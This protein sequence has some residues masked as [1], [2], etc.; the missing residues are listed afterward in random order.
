[1][2]RDSGSLSTQ[3]IVKRTLPQQSKKLVT[4]VERGGQEKGSSMISG[5]LFSAIILDISSNTF[6][7][8]DFSFLVSHINMI[9]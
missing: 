9:T 2:I 4:R 6:N 1:V 7:R 5:M 3:P 8:E